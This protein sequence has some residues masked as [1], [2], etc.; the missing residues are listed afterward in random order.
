M[1]ALKRAAEHMLQA[2]GEQTDDSLPEAAVERMSVDVRIGEQTEVVVLRLRSGQLQ[3]SCTCGVQRC[4]H[5]R[6]A[7][8]WLVEPQVLQLPV[9]GS[10]KRSS[11]RLE[12]V[13]VERERGG[14]IEPRAPVTWRKAA[15]SGSSHCPRDRRCRSTCGRSKR[16]RRRLA[17]IRSRSRKRWKTP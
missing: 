14:S 12:R 9:A 16:G 11:P 5:A 7:L 4:A 17:R 3:T 6:H 15:V 10:T 13:L 8:R 1:E 2:L